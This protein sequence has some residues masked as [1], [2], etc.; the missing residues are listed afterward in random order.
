[1][2]LFAFLHVYYVNGIP[3]HLCGCKSV[4]ACVHVHICVCMC[5]CA[6]TNRHHC[7]IL[8]CKEGKGPVTFTMA[9]YRKLLV[10]CCILKIDKYFN[11]A[12]A[13]LFHS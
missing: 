8:F 9:V 1:M 7:Y 5:F 2:C 13:I 12:V 11:K 3:V 10:K 4:C 6:L